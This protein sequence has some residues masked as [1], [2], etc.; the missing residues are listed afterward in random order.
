[1][2]RERGSQARLPAKAALSDTPSNPV[3]ASTAKP[4]NMKEVQLPPFHREHIIVVGGYFMIFSAS[5]ARTVTVILNVLPIQS[6]CR[7][8]TETYEFFQI[9]C[10]PSTIFDVL[11]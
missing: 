1:M 11:V 3:V 9:K 8:V 10:V 7:S 4:P 2:Q 5:F 6:V